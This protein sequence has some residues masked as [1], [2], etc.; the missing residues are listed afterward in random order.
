MKWF[1]LLGYSSTDAT[2]EMV[3]TTASPT[4]LTRTSASSELISLDK[5]IRS[6]ETTEVNNYRKY[7]NAGKNIIS[8][9]QP[10]SQMQLSQ[11][12]TGYVHPLSGTGLLLIEQYLQ[13]PLPHAR[14]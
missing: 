14:Q 5:L 7:N 1:P 9:D 6:T 12:R 11:T 8:N 2:E 4:F 3:F 13:T 10:V